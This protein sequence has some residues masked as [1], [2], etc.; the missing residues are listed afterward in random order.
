MPLTFHYMTWNVHL[1]APY[2][3]QRCRAGYI[4]RFHDYIDGHWAVL[5][6]HPKN[7]TPVCTTELGAA[8][9]LK[10]EFDKRN[11]KVIGLDEAPAAYET[12]DQGSSSK[13][14][15]DPHGMIPA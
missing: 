11:T 3:L 2:L 8:A 7:F 14:I 15:I 1:V 4:C 6:S 9:K 12:F 5:F 13:F 10:P